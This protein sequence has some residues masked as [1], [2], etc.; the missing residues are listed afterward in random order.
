MNVKMKFGKRNFSVN[1][2]FSKRKSISITVFPDKSIFAK[3]PVNAKD[4]AVLKILRKRSPW[5]VKQLQFFENFHPILPKKK[6]ISGETHY[7]MGKEFR[8]KVM[9][10]EMEKVQ[11]I[12]KFIYIHVNNIGKPN[13]VKNLLE[14]WYEIH[15]INYLSKRF[16]L[17]HSKY[18]EFKNYEVTLRLRKME[19]RW[20]SCSSGKI[21]SLNAELVKVPAICIDYV[22][23]H[24][25]CHLIYLNH[26][27][28]FYLT[29]TK[30]M[31]DWESRKEKLNRYLI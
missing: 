30:V 28:N 14:R 2:A 27:K 5:I 3:A 10:S 23:V 16:Y 1:L 9:R 24:E 18:L 19:K 13:S 22:I 25:L 12:G 11:L 21:I 29:L 15:S 8:L 7:Y 31:P 26:S 4:E 17:L 20:G 6:F